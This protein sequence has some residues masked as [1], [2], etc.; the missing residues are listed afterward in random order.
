MPRVGL[1]RPKGGQTVTEWGS[2]DLKL[3]AHFLVLWLCF[4]HPKWAA[5]KLCENVVSGH[6]WGSGKLRENV[7]GALG[8]TSRKLC[9]GPLG[10]IWAEKAENP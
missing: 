10:A 1:Q 4:R 6:F 5:G 7:A 2:F 9:P 3:G 8:K